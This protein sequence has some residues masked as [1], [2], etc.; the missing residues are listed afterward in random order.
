MS[1]FAIK[2]PAKNQSALLKFAIERW[3]AWFELKIGFTVNAVENG[4]A[5]Q[6]TP[7][8]TTL[9]EKFDDEAPG[10]CFE[11]VAEGEQP[12]PKKIVKALIKK[13]GTY[14]GNG[15]KTLGIPDNPNYKRGKYVVFSSVVEF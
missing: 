2:D 5:N 10:L 11:I 6:H 4:L 13:L 1:L 15:K 12:K 8:G 7:V 3:S 14:F 9:C